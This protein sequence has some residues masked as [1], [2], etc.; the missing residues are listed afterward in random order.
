MRNAKKDL[1]LIK[2]GNKIGADELKRDGNFVSPTH[3]HEHFEIYLLKSTSRRYVIS[4]KFYDIS[5]GDI[6]LVAPFEVHSTYN[7]DNSKYHRIL[8]NFAEDLL[9][10]E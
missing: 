5:K 10:D 9:D 2:I 7:I 6:V 4:D 8:I 1:D 3:Y